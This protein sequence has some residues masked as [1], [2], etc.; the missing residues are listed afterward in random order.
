MSLPASFFIEQINRAACSFAKDELAFLALTS[1]VERPF[2]DRL[3]WGVFLAL[4]GSEY[5]VS[6]ECPVSKGVRADLVVFKGARPI[7]LIEAKAMA[8]F[9][10]TRDGTMQREYPNALQSDLD[11][12]ANADLPDADIFCLLL[13][14]HPLSLLPR[15]LAGVVKYVTG[16]NRAFDRFGTASEIRAVSERNLLKCTRQDKLKASGSFEGG[17]A[18][19]VSIELLWWLFGPFR[20]SADL[21]ILRE[22]CR[23]TARSMA[24]RKKRRA[25]STRA[26][27]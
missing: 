18:Y 14:S 19:G 26:L 9:D 2:L 4:R 11:R 8:S 17:S 24:T 21:H 1:K 5:A 10:C 22:Q 25:P 7:S 3:S 12:Y 13:S 6:R 16:F 23:L 20:S 27:N 15:Q